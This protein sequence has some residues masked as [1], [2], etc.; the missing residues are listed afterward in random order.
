MPKS[1]Y[2]GKASGQRP[3][4]SVVTLV[5]PPATNRNLMPILFLTLGWF[6]IQMAMA[7]DA[8]LFQK[9]LDD[10]LENAFHIALVLGLGPLAGITV[11]PLMGWL[12]DKLKRRG[13]SRMTVIRIS[14]LLS[15]AGTAVFALQMSLPWLV[16]AVAFFFV[17]F[18]VLCVNY[19]ALVTETANRKALLA[20]KGTVSGFIAGFSGL[21]GFGMFALAS[22]AGDTPA[23]PVLA[24]AGVLL[25]CFLL[26]FRFAPPPKPVAETEAAGEQAARHEKAMWSGWNLAFYALPV[27]ALIPRFEKKLLQAP[28]QLPIFRLFLVLFFSWVGI[29]ALRGFFVL[30]AINALG[31]SFSQANVPLAVLTLVMVLAAIPLG[32]L[33]DKFDNRVLFR[34]SLLVYALVC[35]AGY[36]A[37]S[38]LTAAIVLSVFIGVS[39]AGMIVLPL[40]LLFKLCPPRSEGVYAGFYNLFMSVPQLYSLFITGR[41]IDYFHDYRVIL[42]VGAV[43]VTIAMLL[44]FRLLVP[45]PANLSREISDAAAG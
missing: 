14:L 36:F 25:A 26:V 31:L 37:V 19:R 34:A 11:Q 22:V 23:I 15:L 17:A 16:A 42:P 32:K 5:K 12:G 29:Q 18:N 8:T 41:L 43:A 6:G 28:G 35:L 38:D 10:R 13:I 4:T 24:S 7:L 9:L 40:T 39:F 44:T 1:R 33:A 21:G 2:D 27:L 45:E 3:S 20:H 30:Y